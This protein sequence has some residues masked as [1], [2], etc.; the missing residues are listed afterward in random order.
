LRSG[1]VGKRPVRHTLGRAREG[2]F[3]KK[4][5]KE[6]WRTKVISVGQPRGEGLAAQRK[7][8]PGEGRLGEELG[9][10]PRGGVGLT[11]GA[12]G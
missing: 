11:R 1:E 5:K 12:G 10:S 8:A 6:V 9:R 4:K 3:E 2:K 7:G